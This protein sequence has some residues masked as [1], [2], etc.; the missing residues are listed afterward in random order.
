MKYNL[1]L[2]FEHHDKVTVCWLEKGAVF[3]GLVKEDQICRDQTSSTLVFPMETE[4]LVA[5]CIINKECIAR[6]IMRRWWHFE[7]WEA[8][9]TAYPP[10]TILLPTRLVIPIQTIQYTSLSAIWHLSNQNMQ[11]HSL[12]RFATPREKLDTISKS[13]PSTSISCLIFMRTI[14]SR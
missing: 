2:F 1:L 4:W 10:S 3:Y 9:K 13:R 5:L 8:S 14:D 12:S 11:M 6:G 7:S